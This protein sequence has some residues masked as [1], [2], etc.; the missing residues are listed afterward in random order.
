MF[1][2]F[3][4]P[5][6]LSLSWVLALIDGFPFGPQNLR[7]FGPDNE[8]N[9]QMIQS[10]FM[11]VLDNIRLRNWK[12]QEMEGNLESLNESLQQVLHEMSSWERY[13]SE[14]LSG[15]LEWSPVHRSEKFWK[16]NVNRFE[17]NDFEVLG[18][19]S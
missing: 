8:N 6:S 14:I 5:L 10:G 11:R 3:S 13:K 17:E 15:N 4:L 1:V 7:N 12:D 9:V 16:E 2:I 19:V 18:F